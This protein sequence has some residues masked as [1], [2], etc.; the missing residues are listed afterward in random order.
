MKKKHVEKQSISD[1][2]QAS[3]CCIKEAEYNLK[4]WDKLHKTLDCDPTACSSLLS[5]VSPNDDTYLA[6]QAELQKNNFL[7]DADDEK[8]NK[9]R[10]RLGRSLHGKMRI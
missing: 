8:K 2:I 6:A 10:R 4:R 5:L 1:T 7:Q 3:E 9:K